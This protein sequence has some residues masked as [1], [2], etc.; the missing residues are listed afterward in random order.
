MRLGSTGSSRTP[1]MSLIT[2]A[3]GELLEAIKTELITGRKFQDAQEK[4]RERA[5]AQEVIASRGHKTIPGLGKLA[6]SLPEDD[7]WALV[8]KYGHECMTDRTFL[9]DLQRLEPQFAGAKL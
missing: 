2:F 9:K 3:E 8:A 6:I 1:R 7:Y 5:A 4:A